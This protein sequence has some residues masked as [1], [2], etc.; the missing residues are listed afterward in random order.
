MST[1]RI[2]KPLAMAAVLLAAGAAPALAHHTL[3]QREE[4]LRGREKYLEL[5]DRVAPAFTLKDADERTV[6]LEDFRGKVVILNFVFATCTDVCPLHSELIAELQ[7]KM[8]A[9]RDKVQ[10]ITVT[11]HPEFDTPEILKPYGEQHGLDPKNWTFLTSGP[12]RPTETREL[13]ESYGLKFTPVGN[14]QFVHGIVT[15]VIDQ[16]G[17]LR[18]RYHGLRFNLMSLIVHV[19]TVIN[20]Y[21]K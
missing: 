13:A 16:K 9:L 20:E 19:S 12:E 1:I 11:T 18:A 14:G 8:S 17:V 21:H 4:A 10:F 7:R 15:H 6:G 3:K 5:T 2:T